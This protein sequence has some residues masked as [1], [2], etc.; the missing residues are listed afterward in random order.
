MTA[1]YSYK[2]RNATELSFKAGDTI[3]LRAGQAVDGHWLS[4]VLLGTHARM[5]GKLVPANHLVPKEA[6][7][8]TAYTA[9]VAVHARGPGELSCEAGAIIVARKDDRGK[10]VDDD[11]W[12]SAVEAGTHPRFCAHHPGGRPRRVEESLIAVT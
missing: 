8:T 11:T 9:R 6:A 3:E 7:E 4:G 1:R 5:P 2:A 10:F 12:L